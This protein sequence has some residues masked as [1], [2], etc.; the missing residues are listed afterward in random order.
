MKRNE[1]N[2][3]LQYAKEKAKRNGNSNHSKTMNVYICAEILH[4]R[5]ADLNA[6]VKPSKSTGS[7][8]METL[9]SQISIFHGKPN[10][11]VITMIDNGNPESA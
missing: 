2:A 6:S 3:Y 7:K 10:I 5:I 8:A 9:K 1:I 11:T 4:A